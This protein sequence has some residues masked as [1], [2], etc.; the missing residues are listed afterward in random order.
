MKNW[1]VGR[2]KYK[3]GTKKQK[4]EILGHK[5]GLKLNNR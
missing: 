5:K 3:V 4:H 2:L 1:K